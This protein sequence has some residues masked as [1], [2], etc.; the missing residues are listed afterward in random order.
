M[1]RSLENSIGIHKALQETEQQGE[2][3]AAVFRVLIAA[4]LAI[5][6]AMMVPATHSNHHFFGVAIA[7]AFLGLVGIVLASR[8]IYHPVLPYVFVLI[9]FAII[10]IALGMLAS[11]HGM[12]MSA[13]LSLPLFSLAFVVL[14]HAALRYR[15]WLIV[16]A[17]S[18]FVSL[19]IIA[20]QLISPEQ[21]IPVSH[22]MMSHD[23]DSLM[24]LGSTFLPLIFFTMASALLF[25]VVRRTETL[26]NLARLD[27]R[28]VA[29]LSRFF[30]PDISRRLISSDLAQG[31]YGNRQN[32]AVLFID[33]RGFTRLAEGM[34]PEQ[35]TEFLSSF[36]SEVCETVFRHGGTV[37]KFI[38]DAVLVV[39]GTP[40]PK[41]DDARRAVKAAQALSQGIKEW[42]ETRS[43]A[44]KSSALVGI[45]PHYGEV[46]AGVLESN[47]IL[48]HTVIGDTVNI[49]Q[50][51]ER[52][53]RDLGANVVLSADLVAASGLDPGRLGYLLERDRSL[54]GH[55]APITVF[56]D[57]VEIQN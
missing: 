10:T 1:A 4:V 8:K 2:F 18:A 26:A 51:L 12:G 38:G 5:S 34:S 21:A 46:F 33:I 13:A 7:Y 40:E 11:M 17:A 19:E 20:A 23:Q 56:Y 6:I 32:V 47:E 3:V 44:G 54:A 30:S 25:Y 39:F 55:S 16:F 31:A 49:A 27:G 22:G 41:P 45:G 43:R 50:R 42:C 36:R 37:D 48:E 24:T 29:Q 35:L 52:L 28:R 9:D 14:I 15:P 57:T 53:S